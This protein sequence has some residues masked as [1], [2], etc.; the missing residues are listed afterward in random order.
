MTDHQ[1]K[2]FDPND[3]LT[4]LKSRN[5]TS[6][7]LEVKWR[8]LWFNEQCPTGKIT[9]LDKHIDPNQAVEKED[10]VWNNETRKSEKVKKY[11]KGFAWFLVRVEDGMG[12][13]GE[14]VG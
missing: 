3:H 1:K 6:D 8:I 14:D 10:S 12:R 13:V 7:Y 2:S 11:G 9:I 4:K 5:G